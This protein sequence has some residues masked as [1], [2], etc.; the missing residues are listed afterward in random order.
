V[1]DWDDEKPLCVEE[2]D[3]VD[4]VDEER[5]ED[6]EEREDESEGKGIEP[7]LEANGKRKDFEQ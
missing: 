1:F 7:K 2:E 5:K 4:E 3:D 6:M